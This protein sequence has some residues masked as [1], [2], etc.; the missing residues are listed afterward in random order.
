M[1]LQRKLLILT[2]VLVIG[3]AIVH[4]ETLK[5]QCLRWAGEDGKLNRE[6]YLPHTFNKWSPWWWGCVDKD[7]D[8]LWSCDEY[9]AMRED[10]I[11]TSPAS[12]PDLTTLA[13]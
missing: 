11:D 6:E 5:E 10:K 1:A 3:I 9:V 2:V 7:K 12:C 4:S 8:G 13:P